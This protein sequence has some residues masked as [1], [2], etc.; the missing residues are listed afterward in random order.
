M[1]AFS[2]LVVCE[3]AADQRTGA[4]LA[5]RV[6][7]E[8]V[9]WIDSESIDLHRFWRGLDPG[10]DHLPWRSVKSLAKARGV[11]LHGHFREEPGFPDASAT[12]L[13]LELARRSEAQPDAVVLLR[14][15]DGETERR[16]GLE[17]ARSAKEW[18]FPIAIGVA[19]LNRECWV[20]AGFEP[21]KSDEERALAAVQS[22]LGFDPRD[23]LDSL[24]GRAGEARNAKLI[25]V[26][27]SGGSA[28]REEACW[29]ECSLDLLRSRGTAT[30]LADFLD[31]VRSRIVPLFLSTA[32]RA[33]R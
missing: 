6:L 33:A 18:P 31:E 22:D 12:R 27:L 8:S 23:R 29:N 5:D 9:D 15:S 28:E 30:G 4:C 32:P 26:R 25:L 19:H 7:C 24:R 11:K 2:L 1:T 17:Q 21:G 13:V 16:T 14:D 20:L 3:A 10:S